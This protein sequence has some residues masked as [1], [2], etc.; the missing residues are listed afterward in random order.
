MGQSLPNNKILEGSKLKA[1]ADE[2]SNEAEKLKFVLGWLE[3]MVGKGE[4][5]GFQH[6]LLFPLCFQKASFFGVVKSR[7]CVVNG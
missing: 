6:F 2:N 7:N 3:N 4:N 1:F 5:A